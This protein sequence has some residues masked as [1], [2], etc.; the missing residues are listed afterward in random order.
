[1]IFPPKQTVFG[2]THLRP[3]SPATHRLHISYQQNKA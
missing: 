1:M 3:P 2:A